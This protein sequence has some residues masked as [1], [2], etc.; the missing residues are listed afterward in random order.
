MRRMLIAEVG[1]LVVELFPSV[2]VLAS[3]IEVTFDT[4]VTIGLAGFLFFEKEKGIGVI[5]VISFVFD[6]ITPLDESGFCL[7]RRTVDGVSTMA[8]F[9]N[10][11]FR[12]LGREF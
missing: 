5:D 7:A 1:L 6:G 2:G 12:F 4:F 8:S 9:I 3:F 10:S 11:L